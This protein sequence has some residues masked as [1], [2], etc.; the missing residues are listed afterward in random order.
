MEG[1]DVRE[2]VAI[3]VEDECETFAF[4]GFVFWCCRRAVGRMVGGG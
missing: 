3:E 2:E 4:A 1:L